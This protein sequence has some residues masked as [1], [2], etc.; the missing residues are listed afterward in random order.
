M[1]WSRFFDDLEA[2]LARQDQA[3]LAADAAEH[4]RAAH[5][6]TDLVQRLVASGSAPLTLTVQ[7]AGQ[8]SGVLSEVGSDWCVLRTDI[9][10][11][12]RRQDVLVRLPTVLRIQGLPVHVD[13]REGAGQRRFALGSALRALARDRSVLRLTDVGG[14]QQSG[15]IDRV[16]R[17]YVD[18]AD[19]AAD[20][21]RRAEAVRSWHSVPLW[22]LATVR[23][24]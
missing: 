20:L 8:L 18:L 23:Q 19:H 7:G 14:G 16:G 1:R 24:I 21:P 11:P 17:D 5:S 22:A 13:Q 12:Q 4:A 10:G 6:R 3:E 15:T 2:Q 9:V